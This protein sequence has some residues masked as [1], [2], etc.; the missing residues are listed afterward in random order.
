M[1]ITAK[2]IRIG[3]VINTYLGSRTVIEIRR[4]SGPHKDILNYLYFDD[5]GNMQ[6][7]VQPHYQNLF[8]TF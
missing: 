6:K 3:T 7:P 8:D 1:T 2:E 5:D 4:N